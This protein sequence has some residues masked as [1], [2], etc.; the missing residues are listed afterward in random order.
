MPAF[1]TP[2][3]LAIKLSAQGER[4]VHSGHPWIFSKNIVK[5]NH[6][7]TA[8]DIAVIFGKK[9]NQVIGV[10]L[11]DPDSPIRIKMLHNGPVKID[12]SFFENR[13]ANAYALRLPLLET[14]TN[15]YRLLFGENDG[16][17]GCIVD[18][19]AG[20]A[21]L[22]LYSAIWFPYLTM[23]IDAIALVTSCTTIVLRLSRKLQQDNTHGYTEGAILYGTL[24]NENVIFTEYGIRFQAHVLKGHK[25]GYFLDHR[26]NRHTVGKM[27]KGKSV[28]DVFSYAGGFS[29]HALVH[30]ATEVT[31]ID[32]SEQ[33]LEV[34]KTNAA[35]NDFTGIHK[36]QCGDAFELLEEAISQR[37]FYD[38]VV[39]DPPSF[40]KTQND[41]QKALK[42]Y[43]QLAALGARLVAPKGILV[44][45]SCSSRVIAQDFFETNFNALAATGIRFNLQKSTAHDIDHP[46]AFPEGAYL[47][48][49]Y[50]KR[51]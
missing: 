33:A 35:L 12:N 20:V 22:K 41:I 31:S 42:K 51:A 37:K 39:I 46:V 43:A 44:L 6:E 45:A 15:S 38:I 19:Y 10:G 32:I 36:T 14:K 28:L 1:S 13:V 23:L 29:V 48:C 2:K 7:G 16:L 25:T 27:A 18:V 8:G 50:Y 40:A 24:E 4:S 47:K 9:S 30:G 3:R 34:A 5:I 11:Y 49:G 17:P 26:S 21:V